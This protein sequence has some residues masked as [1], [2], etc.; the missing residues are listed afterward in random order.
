MPLLGMTQKERVLRELIHVP[1]G[2]TTVELGDR[3]GLPEGSLRTI[4]WEMRKEGWIEPVGGV[5]GR[6]RYAITNL[7]RRHAPGPPP[8]AIAQAFATLQGTLELETHR[9]THP[10]LGPAGL[11]GQLLAFVNWLVETKPELLATHSPSVRARLEAAVL[12]Y[13]CGDTRELM[14]QL[15]RLTSD[16]EG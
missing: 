11:R 15:E 16:E 5:R 1:A 3:T 6:Y 12:E 13:L 2:L 9:S 10:P 7:G 8:D 4:I 14:S